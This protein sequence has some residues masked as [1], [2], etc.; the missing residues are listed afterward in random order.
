MAFRSRKKKMIWAT[1][2]LAANLTLNVSSVAEAPRHPSQDWVREAQLLTQDQILIQSGGSATAVLVDFRGYYLTHASGWNTNEPQWLTVG[3]EYRQLELLHS[4]RFTELLLLVD[5]DFI[6]GKI[7]PIQISDR[8]RTGTPLVA[9]AGDRAVPGEVTGERRIGISERSQRA[10]PLL[11]MQF[12]SG[13]LES[14]GI[15]FDTRGRLVGFVEASSDPVSFSSQVELPEALV[16]L[17]TF[18]FSF[19]SSQYGPSGVM[20]AYCLPP[21]IVG[22]AIRGLTGPDGKVAHPYIGFLF[23]QR[24]F[25]SGVVL[26][27]ILA[28]S[29]AEVAGLETGDVL[30]RL[31]GAPIPNAIEFAAMLFELEPGRTVTF[32]VQRGERTFNVEVTVGVTPESESLR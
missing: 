13:R 16:A 1:C 14:Q 4:D 29:P 15:V 9:I 19:R 28:D 18:R 17:G 24:S 26:D 2:F 25:E 6:I 5:H 22:R 23:R 31:N 8:L 7:P 12:E 30:W 21:D 32:A 20:R 27:Q 10:F 3:G 11:E